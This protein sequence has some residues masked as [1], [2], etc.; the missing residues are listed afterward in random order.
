[1]NKKQFLLC[2]K[3]FSRISH[4][5]LLNE[6]VLHNFFAFYQTQMD[7]CTMGGPLADTFS[8]IYIVIPSLSF[9]ADLQMTFLADRN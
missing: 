3:L 4:L 1:M 2:K 7:G 9:I 8:D 5:Q 6:Y